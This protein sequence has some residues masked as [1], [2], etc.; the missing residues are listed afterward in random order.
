MAS[1]CLFA[2]WPKVS[3]PMQFGSYFLGGGDIKFKAFCLLISIFFFPTLEIGKLADSN[4]Y[5]LASL[6]YTKL[7]GTTFS[8][9]YSYNLPTPFL[10]GVGY[11]HLTLH[12]KTCQFLEIIKFSGWTCFSGWCR[13]CPWP[14]DFSMEMTCHQFFSRLRQNSSE[15]FFNINFKI[16][17]L[18]KFFPHL[19]W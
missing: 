16:S 19:F 12:Y 6:T 2:K 5:W 13:C 1:P 9:S 8:F 10:L 7:T 11:F 4:L 14:S 15:Q 17:H 3:A 18:K